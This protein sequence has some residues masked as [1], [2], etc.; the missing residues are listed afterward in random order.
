[1]RT[2]IDIPDGVYRKLKSNAALDGSTVKSLVLKL[3]HRE[4]DDGKQAVR[5]EFPLIR[6]K[7]SRKLNLTN[8]EIEEIMLG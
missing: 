6:G 2:T 3:V 7:E 5:T 4:L 1:M 8:A